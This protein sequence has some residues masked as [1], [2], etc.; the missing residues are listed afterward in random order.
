MYFTFVRTVVKLQ[1]CLLSL[2]VLFSYVLKVN[3]VVSLSL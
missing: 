1:L 2:L 3:N